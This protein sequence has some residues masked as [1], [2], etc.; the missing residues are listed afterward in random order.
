MGYYQQI[1]SF[2]VRKDETSGAD[3]R[4]SEE[5]AVQVVILPHRHALDNQMNSRS[6]AEQKEREENRMYYQ[7]L[8]EAAEQQRQ[9]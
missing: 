8:A 7:R 2:G 6:N 3:A 4:P 1:Q 9:K 5:G